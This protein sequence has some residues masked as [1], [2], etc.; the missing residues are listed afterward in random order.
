MKYLCI[1]M[2]R[3]GIE[4]VYGCLSGPEIEVEQHIT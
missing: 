1:R 4:Q 2:L 3:I